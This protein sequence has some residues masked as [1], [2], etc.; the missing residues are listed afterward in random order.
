MFATFLTTLLKKVVPTPALDVQDLLPG[1]EG[2]ENNP[3]IDAFVNNGYIE[4]YLFS[5]MRGV[6]RELQQAMMSLYDDLSTFLLTDD[7]GDSRTNHQNALQLTNAGYFTHDTFL[8]YEGMDKVC[9][10]E[11]KRGKLVIG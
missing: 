7:D 8:P 4:L 11:T 10:V 2:I 3:T 9:V 1:L 5:E 6:N